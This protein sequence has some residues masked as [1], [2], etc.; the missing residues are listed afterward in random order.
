M[1]TVSRNTEFISCQFFQRCDHEAVS[2]VNALNKTIDDN[3]KIRRCKT[4]I[5]SLSVDNNNPETNLCF[6]KLIH[7][8]DDDKFY[9]TPEDS[10]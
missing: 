4:A 6:K 3:R 10:K 1:T 9:K 2:K 7:G 5:F 8:D